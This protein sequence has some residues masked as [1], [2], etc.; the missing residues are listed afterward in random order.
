MREKHY[1]LVKNF[2]KESPI[3]SRD[4]YDKTIWLMTDACGID[5][6]DVISVL[7]QVGIKREELTS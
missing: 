5:R 1:S 6:D 4:D 7:H 3:K 2:V